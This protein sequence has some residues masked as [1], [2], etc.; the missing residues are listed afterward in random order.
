MYIFVGSS[1][2]KYGFYKNKKIFALLD[3]NLSHL[4][5]LFFENNQTIFLV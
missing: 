2:S 4:P 3:K 1:T 5:K